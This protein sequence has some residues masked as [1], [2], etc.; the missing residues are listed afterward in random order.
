MFDDQ[1][2]NTEDIGLEECQIST[3]NG[4]IK[5]NNVMETSSLGVYAIGDVIGPP[6]L[7][8]VASTEGII[9]AEHLSGCNPEPMEYS[10]IPGCTYCHPEVASVGLSEQ[11]ALDSGF[12]IKVGNFPFRGLGKSMASGDTEGFVK[13]IYDAKHGEMLGCH[14]IGAEATNIITEAVIAR[15]LEATYHEVL[16]SIHPHPT[17]SE[18]ILEAS[19]NAYGKSIH[20]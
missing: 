8:H 5:V 9:A 11:Q 19:A 6:W 1:K 4:W 14:I 17:L 16:N 15:K 2:G 18:A 13:I 3:N 10:N 7:A 20:I 12:K